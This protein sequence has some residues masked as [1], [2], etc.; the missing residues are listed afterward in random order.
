MWAIVIK[1]AQWF[2]VGGI[3]AFMIH[4]GLTVAVFSGL[5]ILITEALNLAIDAFAGLPSIAFNLALLSGAATFFNIIGSALLTRVA[6][7]T[8]TQSMNLKR[9]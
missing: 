7:V 9:S 8:L 6:L 1:I 2:A 5:E 3:P 4:A